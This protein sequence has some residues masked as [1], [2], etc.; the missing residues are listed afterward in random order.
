MFGSLVIVYPTPHK[1]GELVLR[2]KDREWSF[3]ANAM[4]SFQSTPSLAYVAFYS[5]IEHEVLKITS[6]FRVTVTYNLYLVPRAVSIIQAPALSDPPA[7]SI[8]QNLKDST[9]FQT[10]LHRL[11]RRP[12]FMPNGGILAFS[13][14]HLYP[15]TFDTELQ[16]M[17]EYLKGEDAHVYQSCQELGLEPALRMIYS[18]RRSWEN[19]QPDYGIML[20]AIVEDPNYDYERTDY[21]RHLVDELDGIPVNLKNDSV[22]AHSEWSDRYSTKDPGQLTWLTDFAKSTNELKDRVLAYGNEVTVGFVY[23]SP[24]LIVRIDPAS[25]RI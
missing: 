20:E 22:A 11:L 17:I 19:S 6:G 24:C 23:C 7:A 2:H 8:K 13:L 9:N 5:D 1:G 3:D 18:R 14:A 12:E 4:M 25:Y 21:E 16:E 15:V 10:T